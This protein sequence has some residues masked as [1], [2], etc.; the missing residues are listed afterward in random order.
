MKSKEEFKR[1]RRGANSA[2]CDFFAVPQ[3]AYSAP[4]GRDSGDLC[5]SS[6]C[7]RG[8]WQSETLRQCATSVP[9]TFSPP[10]IITEHEGIV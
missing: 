7:F 10:V 4:P 6:W 8:Q 5:E 3:G 9:R 1:A 2:S